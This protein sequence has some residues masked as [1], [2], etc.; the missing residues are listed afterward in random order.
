ML[1]LQG[2]DEFKNQFQDLLLNSYSK[3][4]QIV[5]AQLSALEAVMFSLATGQFFMMDFLGD[6]VVYNPEDP[7]NAA[8]GMCKIL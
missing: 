7:N 3:S 1:D 2:A 6:N 4:I 8:G 5:K